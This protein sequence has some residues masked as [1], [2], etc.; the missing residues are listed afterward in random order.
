VEKWLCEDSVPWD[1]DARH[2]QDA[3][4][5][6]YRGRHIE[7]PTAGR[8]ERLVRSTVRTHEAEICAGTAAKLLPRIR[9]AM[10]ALIDASIPSD[11]QNADEGSDGRNTT[12]S[13]LKPDPGRVSLKRVRH[14][15]EQLRQMEALELPDNLFAEIQ[16]KSL[17]Q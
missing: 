6:W 14:E 3:V 11:D 13:V 16:P 5:E 9:Q 12:F 8:I 10:D 4:H 17:H 2:L 7:P 15:V 1:H